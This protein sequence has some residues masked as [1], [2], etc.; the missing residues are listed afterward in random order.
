MNIQKYTD[1]DAVNAV[2]DIVGIMVIE[3]D[4]AVEDELESKLGWQRFSA[5]KNGST[6]VTI[7]IPFIFLSESYWENEILSFL[8]NVTNDMYMD[9]YLNYIAD[10]SRAFEYHGTIYMKASSRYDKDFALL[11]LHELGHAVCNLDHEDQTGY[12]MNSNYRH[13]HGLPMLI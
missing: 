13:W 2:D 12:I 10:E 8:E 6:E 1:T 11:V 4:K 3:A 9:K 7:T 5:L